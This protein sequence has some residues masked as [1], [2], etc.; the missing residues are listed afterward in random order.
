MVHNII[1]V[2]DVVT[3]LYVIIDHGISAPGHGI[4]V[5]DCLNATE[6]RFLFQ[7]MCTE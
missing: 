5:V 4:E 6:K 2:V 1:F 3:R 7:L